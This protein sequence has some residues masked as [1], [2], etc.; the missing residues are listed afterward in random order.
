MPLLYLLVLTVIYFVVET[1]GDF[2]YQS[3]RSTIDDLGFTFRE[4]AQNFGLTHKHGLYTLNPQMSS[5]KRMIP[6]SASVAAADFDNDGWVDLFFTAGRE[7]QR[8]FLY[9]NMQGKGFRDVTVE[10]GL[11]DDQNSPGVAMAAAFLDYDQDGFKDLFVAR[12]GCNSLFRNTG[13]GRFIDVSEATGIQKNCRYASAVA[14]LDYDGDG[15]TDLYIG[16][17]FDVTD[18]QNPYDYII[19][20]PRKSKSNSPGSENILLRNVDGKFFDDVTI[21]AGAGDV[22]FVWGIGILDA[23]RDRKPDIFLANDFSIDRFYLNTG[24]KFEDKTETALGSQ[25]SSG[26][27]SAEI[28]DYDN[29]GDLDVFVANITASTY[30]SSLKNLLYRANG[31]ATFHDVAQE[32]GVDRCGFAWGA[33]FLD[34]DHDG[35][36][37]IFVAN[38]FFN[39]GA[40]SYWYRWSTFLSMPK[41]LVQDPRVAPP[42]DGYNIGG[43]ER[44]CMFLQRDGKFFDVAVE[45]G[46]DDTFIGRGVATIDVNNDGAVDIITANHDERPTLYLGQVT[47]PHHWIG[48]NLIANHSNK[49]ALGTWITIRS[50]DLK[51]VREIYPTNGFGSQSDPRVLVGLGLNESAE[52]EIQ[53]PSGIVQRISS[54]AVDRYIDIKERTDE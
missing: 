21:E 32:L 42:T 54:S 6:T 45:A 25:F 14:I 30:A 2:S 8:N 40:K 43:N 51:Q 26:N 23:N 1:Y 39:G 28:G 5:L 35:R 16:N 52:I 7:K 34:A 20:V 47:K 33:K 50:G 3:K 17:N 10:A 12:A 36:L 31:D 27:M 11:G 22:G 18:L 48:L 13:H 29:D 41:F 49:D 44:N 15:W 46:F 19:Y 53:W 37:D 4:A 38:G 9:K 24:G